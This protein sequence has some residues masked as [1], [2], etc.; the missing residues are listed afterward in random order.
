MLTDTN[1]FVCTN[2]DLNRAVPS[3]LIAEEHT[4]QLLEIPLAERDYRL[5]LSEHNLRANQLWS[6]MEE[7]EQGILVPP[8]YLVLPILHL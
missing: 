2:H 7:I 3:G 5:T 4:R 6:S 8:L 1:L